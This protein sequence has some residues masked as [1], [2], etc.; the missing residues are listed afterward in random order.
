MCKGQLFGEGEIVSK[1]RG[2]K[3]KAISESNDLCLLTLPFEKFS[4]IFKSTEDKEALEKYSKLKDSWRDSHEKS[5]S[6]VNEFLKRLKTT[7]I[8]ELQMTK[9]D[10][11]KQ[12]EFLSPQ[13]KFLQKLRNKKSS[14]I[15]TTPLHSDYEL[16]TIFKRIKGPEPLSSNENFTLPAHSQSPSTRRSN[17][18][19]SE[20]H[21]FWRNSPLDKNEVSQFMLSKKLKIRSLFPSSPSSKGK[22]LPDAFHTF[23][24]HTTTLTK[25]QEANE[26][27]L[28][29]KDVSRF[30]SATRKLEETI[31]NFKIRKREN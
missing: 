20:N 12:K 28:M 18:D 3:I 8:Q 22:A 7:N 26:I 14:R 31:Y 2:R 17:K 16:D 4:S 25:R 30:S 23:R 5:I 27:S 9:E 13:I 21:K 29:K 24:R 11:Q 19:S 10:K 15:K 6:K 1:E